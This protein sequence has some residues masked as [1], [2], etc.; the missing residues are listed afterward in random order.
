M[1]H[2]LQSIRSSLRLCVSA[3][4][5]PR[6]LPIA[7]LAILSACSSRPPIAATPVSIQTPSLT[8]KLTIASGDYVITDHANGWLFSGTTGGISGA[9]TQRADLD[10]L[11]KCVVI[12]FNVDDDGP[13]SEEIRLY[14]DQPIVLFRSTCLAARSHP[15][16]PFPSIKP[17][18]NLHQFGFDDSVFAPPSFNG[19][20]GASPWL[21]FDDSAKAVIISPASDF[22]TATLSRDSD[23]MLAVSAGPKLTCIPAGHCQQTLLVLGDSIHSAWN[24]WGQAMTDLTGKSRPANDAD[25]GLKRFGY[26]TDN[27]AS[28]YYNYDPAKGYQGTLLAVRDAFAKLKIPLAYMQLDS[29]WYIK[30]TTGF[31]GKTGEPFKNNKL[32]RGTWNC[33]GGTMEYVAHPFVLPDGLAGF[34]Q[35]IGMPL[36]THNRWIDIASPYRKKYKISGIAAVDPKWWDD[37]TDYLKSSGVSV[38]EQDWL[39]DLSA[40]SPEFATTTTA[41]DAFMDNMARSCRERGMSVQYCMGT[42][43]HYMQGSKYDNLTT[44]RVCNDRFARSNWA[45]AMYVSQMSTAL[46]EWPWVDNFRSRELPN[47][48]IATLS[49]GMVGV[50]D[51][52]NKID[53]DNIF[54]SIRADG[55]IVKPDTALLP[56]DRTYVSDATD[57][58]SPMIAAAYTDD[59]PLRT[60]YV[61]A[62]PRTARQMKIEFSPAELGITGD[63]WVYDTRTGKCKRIAAGGMFTGEFTNP[64]YRQAWGSFIVAPVTTSGIAFLGD[65]GK[66]ASNGRQRIASIHATSDAL[67]V[68]VVFTDGEKS[69]Q[70]HGYA[71]FKPVIAV[72]S[73]KAGPVNF[74]PATKEFNVQISPALDGGSAANVS[75]MKAHD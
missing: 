33:Y 24:R 73:G 6:N 14:Q 64:E 15:P 23:G 52:I 7:A 49:A 10:R 3:V 61:F 19:G 12:A 44:I 20:G 5:N 50:S 51:E 28:Y 22:M 60:A 67:Q 45:N 34:H 37:I 4:K 42:P 26:W 46:G 2:L 48:I 41:G 55:V 1:I 36:I 13:V 58:H 70:L 69:V 66:I 29:W 72:E 9:I 75:L 18:A 25:N 11:G 35:K 59:G 47:M 40:F 53:T 32:P 39:V 17:P 43:R 38:Y 30:T 54:Q 27:G 62:Y 56:I 16:R 57:H 74:D 63:A 65:T 21:L 68:S 31:D 8:A 71:A